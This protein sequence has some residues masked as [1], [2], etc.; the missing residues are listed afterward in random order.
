V[1]TPIELPPRTVA[2]VVERFGAAGKRWVQ[3]QPL[4]LAE[5]G[6]TWGLTFDV[7]FETGLPINAVYAVTRNRQSFVLKTGYPNPE[8]FTELKMLPLWEGQLGC[9]QLLQADSGIGCFL[10]QRVAP[11]NSFRRSLLAERSNNIPALFEIT[12]VAVPAEHDFPSY[13]DWCQSAFDQYRRNGSEPGMLDHIEA[14]E[15]FLERLLSL[16]EDCL[17][18]GDLH[19]ENMLLQNLDDGSTRYVAIDP[20]GVVGPRILEYGRFMHNFVSDEGDYS[21]ESIQSILTKRADALQG[22]WSMQQLLMVGYVDL[23]LSSTWMLNEAGLLESDR[24]ALLRVS[25]GLIEG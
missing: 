24:S 14:A 10:L 6:Q 21:A 1:L 5:I 8:L 9:V 23:V 15:I 19:H 7:P 22:K 20:K 3:E 17:L 12:P 13:K 2:A 16:G 4:R 25:R 11:G 18:H